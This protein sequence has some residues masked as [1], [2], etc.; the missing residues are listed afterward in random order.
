M[1]H[2]AKA[3]LITAPVYRLGEVMYVPHYQD[4]SKFVGPGYN[5]VN[6][7]E[8]RWDELLVMGARRDSYP[9]LSRGK[10]KKHG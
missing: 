6:F 4:D 5:L 7:R 10:A 9:L 1:G 2:D 8:Y 3:E